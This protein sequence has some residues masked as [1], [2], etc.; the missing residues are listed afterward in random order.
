MTAFSQPNVSSSV[1][2]Y[3]LLPEV[4]ASSFAD[5]EDSPYLDLVA[6]SKTNQ[7]HPI[8]QGWGGLMDQ[9][10]YRGLHVRSHVGI[11]CA[12]ICMSL[13]PTGRGGGR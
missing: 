6:A 10:I 3:F 11:T 4:N 13:G 5:K 9:N 1:R 2:I 12:P 8:G 7:V